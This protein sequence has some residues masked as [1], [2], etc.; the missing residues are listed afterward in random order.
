[1]DCEFEASLGFLMKYQISLGYE[2][3]PSKQKN[4]NKTGSEYRTEVSVR[5]WEIVWNTA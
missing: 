4:Q 1:M 2:E 3:G 5:G